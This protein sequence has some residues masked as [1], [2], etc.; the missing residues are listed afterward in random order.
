MCYY[1]L[2]DKKLGTRKKIRK[3]YNPAHKMVETFGQAWV[4]LI[5]QVDLTALLTDGIVAHSFTCERLPG[6]TLIICLVATKYFY[7]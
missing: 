3:L 1:I 2:F 6:S 4:L 7:H 5:C